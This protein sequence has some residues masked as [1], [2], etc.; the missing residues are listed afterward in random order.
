[1]KLTD[2]SL[3]LMFDH[4]Y[5]NRLAGRPCHFE[6]MSVTVAVSF[7]QVRL[8]WLNNERHR[9]MR[10]HVVMTVVLVDATTIVHLGVCPFENFRCYCHLYFHLLC[11]L[12]FDLMQL[13][14]VAVVVVVTKRYFL[15]I[16]VQ[17]DYVKICK[18]EKKIRKFSLECQLVRP[19]FSLI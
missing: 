5:S 10:A 1:M 2:N 12:M 15:L 13:V 4:L 19:L 9:L 3:D 6:M 18:K 7:G 14:L 11:Y 16:S 8:M 17:L